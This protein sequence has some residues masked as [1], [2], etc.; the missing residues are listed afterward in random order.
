MRIRTLFGPLLL[1]TWI[2][3]SSIAA[4][5]RA[6]EVK[7]EK[8]VMYGTV[9]E[10]KL[11]LDAFTP[12]DA[13]Q[14]HPGIVLI[15]GGGFVAG[16]KGFYTPL[17]RRFA[18]KGYAV[19]SL[20][21]RLAP[22]SRYPA[23]VDDVQR[24][25]R[26]IRAHAAAYHVDPDRL[27]ALGDS[28]GGYLVSMLGTRATRDNSDPALAKFSSRV[29]CVVDLYGPS[30]FTIAPSVAGVGPQ[31][32]F[33]LGQFFGK[34]PEQAMELYKDGSPI[35]YVAK[36]SVPFLILHGTGDM[37]VPPD[38][39]RRLHDALKAAGVPVTLIE[40]YKYPH[41]FLNPAAPGQTALLAEEFF[42]R[43][44]KAPA[45]VPPVQ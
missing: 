4:P 30:D 11:L 25:V 7:F 20:N 13:G 10:T 32:L 42:E 14:K 35:I 16:D 1:L 37:L 33:L 34:Q 8:D 31:G 26:W 15:H 6:G 29:Q 36:D 28:A 41:G 18:A 45:I 17:A 24:A 3:A 5:A 43:N 22:K 44:L 38:Q 27:G 12:D 39:S 21:Y 9:E 19:F 23:A 40:F 2:L